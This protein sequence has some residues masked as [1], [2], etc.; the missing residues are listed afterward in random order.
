MI[1]KKNVDSDPVGPVFAAHDDKRPSPATRVGG[2]VQRSEQ[3]SAIAR[4]LLKMGCTQ[5]PPKVN[6][7][8]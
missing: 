7:R 5:F 8:R 4:V 3:K 1:L 6:S 2:A